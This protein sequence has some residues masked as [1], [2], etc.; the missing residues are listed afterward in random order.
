ML[1]ELSEDQLRQYIDARSAFE[2]LL[3][4]RREAAQVRGGLIWRVQKGA[5]YLVRTSPTGSQTGL[6]RESDET[7]QIYERFRRRKAA[8]ESRLKALKD[9]VA[10]MER[11]N[12]AH[13]IGRAP[14]V[15]IDIL[16][17]IEAAG[18][19]DTFCVVGTHAIYAYEAAAGVMVPSGAMATQDIDLL[20]DTRKR[21][22]FVQRMSRAHLSMIDLL[23]KADETFAVVPDIKYTAK[24]ASNFEVDII[25]RM[26]A[27][28]DPHP[29]RL[30]D[31]EDDLWAV[32][33]DTGEQLLAARRFSQ[34]VVGVSGAMAMMHT[35]HPL[36]FV[37]VKERLATLTNRD[38]LKARK[39][40]LQARVVKELVGA[41]LPQLAGP[42]QVDAHQEPAAPSTSPAAP[43]ATPKP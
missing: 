3:D 25:R 13:Q 10:M 37:R 40:L 7:I 12:R 41:Y 28:K 27:E 35:I 43:R 5:R 42:A 26:A 32:Q 33:V 29:L 31:D 14:R 1:T 17:A 38:P 4:A 22:K 2:A 19:A 11:L 34:V 36:D 39:D 6:G 9:K 8:A 16:N 21:L 18:I 30:T 20:M 15:V 24:S 23:R